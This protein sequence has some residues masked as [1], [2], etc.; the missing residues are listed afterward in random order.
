MAADHV[1]D[2]QLREFV[3]GQVDGLITLGL[4]QFRL[5]LQSIL[6]IG[7]TDSDEDIRTLPV[8]KPV[9]EF[10]DD[11][12]AE[13]GAEMPE[14]AGLFRD[15]TANSASRDSPSSARSA[16]KRS[17]SKFIFAPLSK[18]TNCLPLDARP[19]DVRLQARHGERAGRFDDRARVVK[20]IFDGAAISSLPTVTISSTVDWTIG[21][22]CRPTCLTATPSANRPGLSTLTGFACLQCPV[23]GV[24]IDGFDAN[25]L[26]S[27]TTDLTYAPIPAISPPPPTGTKMAARSRGCWRT[28]SSAIVPCPAITRGSS[29]GWTNV[30]PASWAS[31]SECSCASE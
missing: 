7:D 3:I 13:C 10:R 21:K 8:V 14:R 29:K 28:I 31:R 2:V 5:Q 24:R 15:G 25:D 30:S 18:A 17:R 26:T 22:V 20:N 6:A 12:G 23:H 9:I 4:K 11:P 16:T 27:G 19:P 1:A